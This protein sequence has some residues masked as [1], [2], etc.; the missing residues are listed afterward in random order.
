METKV[1]KECKEEKSLSEYY[2][3]SRQSD[4]IRQWCKPCGKVRRKRRLEKKRLEE[5]FNITD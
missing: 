4:G 1:C 2:Q 3:D 5:N